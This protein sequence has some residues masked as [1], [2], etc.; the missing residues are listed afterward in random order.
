MQVRR[1]G[2][3]VKE[4]GYRSRFEMH[5]AEYL[6]QEKVTYGYETCKLKYIVPETKHTYTPDWKIGNVHYESKG[7]FTAVDR[8]KILYV[9]ACNPDTDLRIIFQNADVKLRKGSNTSYGMWATK[10]GIKW[11][12]WRHD[13]EVIISE[14]VTNVEH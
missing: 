7:R 8:Q 1:L 14:V 6:Q 5:I 11:Y 2:K 10:Q 13:K 9:L 12:D 4:A 3:D